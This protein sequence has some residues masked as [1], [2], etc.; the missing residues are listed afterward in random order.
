MQI[1]GAA[2]LTNDT[3][4]AYLFTWGRALRYIDGPDEVHLR[5]V[6]RSELK[7]AQADRGETL[8]YLVQP[9]T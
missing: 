9:Q 3:P 4:L 8:A 5:A 2:G 7:K 6:A 1:F